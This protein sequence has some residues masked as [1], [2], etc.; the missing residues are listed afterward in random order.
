[1]RLSAFATTTAQD[2]QGPLERLMQGQPRGIVLDLRANPGGYLQA[3]LDVAS[4][5]IPEGVLLQQERANGQRDLFR[6]RSGG[7][8][9]AVPLAVLMDHGTAS[10]A[11]ILAAAVRD[12]GR[13]VLIGEPT[14]G[15]GSVQVLHQ[16]ADRSTVRITT[17]RWLSPNEHPLHGEGLAPDIVVPAATNG[18]DPALDRAVRFLL[19]GE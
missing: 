17:A 6:A 9:T 5:F 11:E 16:L 15:K 19:S 1:V 14:Y 7:R 8:A 18:A 12:R 4:E 3:A 10:A 2:L 13:G